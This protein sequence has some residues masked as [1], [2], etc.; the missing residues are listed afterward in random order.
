MNQQKGVILM[1][2]T[3]A[4]LAASLAFAAVEAKANDFLKVLDTI[5]KVVD[6]VQDAAVKDAQASTGFANGAATGVGSVFPTG[7]KTIYVSYTASGATNALPIQAVWYQVK[8]SKDVKI[9]TLS[10]TMPK[11]GAV[12][13]FHLGRQDASWPVGSYKVELVVNFKVLA[14][15]SF[16]V[17][18][19]QSSGSSG[20]WGGTAAAVQAPGVKDLSA[21]TG[22]ASGKAVGA[23]SS[24]TQGVKT[25]YVVYTATGQSSGVKVQAVWQSLSSAGAATKIATLNSTLPDSGVAGEFHLSVNGASWPAG[26]YKVDLL[27]NGAAA[28]SVSFAVEEQ[29]NSGVWSPSSSSAS[30]SAT[31]AASSAAPASSPSSS[32]SAAAPASGEAQKALDD[33]F[34]K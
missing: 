15:V 11:S 5:G 22:F 17:E 10:S 30:P 28:G 2:K 1:N 6:T 34:G 26:S 13:E 23:A 12:G 29:S 4:I 14:S 24:F 27:V 20:V 9:Y 18:E 21:A 33:F 7:T 25:V 16:S 3:A 32:S 8:D 19:A 31:P